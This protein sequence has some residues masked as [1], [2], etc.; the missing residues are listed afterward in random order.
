MPQTGLQRVLALGLVCATASLLAACAN[1]AG[2]TRKL[3]QQAASL[4]AQGDRARGTDFPAA[5]ADY[6][7]GLSHLE[8][9]IN[10][11]PHS[12][13]A[14]KLVSR[15][16]L[17][18]GKSLAQWRRIV[19]RIGRA[20]RMRSRGPL[21]LALAEA[22]GDHVSGRQRQWLARILEATVFGPV[23]PTLPTQFC[24]RLIRAVDKPPRAARLTALYGGLLGGGARSP[25]TDARHLRFR[26]GHS[27]QV[28]DTLVAAVKAR[29][30]GSADAA[31]EDARRLW[32]AVGSAP[33]GARDRL[34]LP[35]VTAEVAAGH[36][37]RAMRLAS[38]L[39]G[40]DARAQTDAMIALTLAHEGGPAA[41]A[42]RALASAERIAAH[43]PI[44]H[45]QYVYLDAASTRALLHENRRGR[46][47]LHRA[48]QAIAVAHAPPWMLLQLI[49]LGD[50]LGVRSSTRAVLAT[51]V[52]GS[53]RGV[54]G[55][56]L[57]AAA[58]RYGEALHH[59]GALAPD[60]FALLAL[61]T[62][63]R[64]SSGGPRLTRKQWH[65]MLAAWV[66]VLRASA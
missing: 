54:A 11:Y 15:Q 21:A 47:D 13:L 18:D 58:G 14:A 31:L 26:G 46:A 2:Q 53:A 42:D 8:K 43:H 28:A 49:Y 59:A 65:R 39:S 64:S 63:V 61:E 55:A 10:D 52:G 66:Q 22:T 12:R 33:P 48:M 32:R 5:Y 44:P 20:A 36:P 51:A 19:H 29:N 50:R 6:R 24:E 17:T 16:A 34:I 9:I 57:F 37:G 3:Q 27:R 40:N 41:D 4:L 56:V 45:R 30:G 35:V 62:G 25:A 38:G 7:R 23:S 1:G 60:Q